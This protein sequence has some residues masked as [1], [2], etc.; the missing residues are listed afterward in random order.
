M[1][2]V[3]LSSMTSGR[4]AVLA[5][6]VRRDAAPMDFSR[7]FPAPSPPPVSQPASRPASPAGS[8]VATRRERS[9]TTWDRLRD[10]VTLSSIADSLADAALSLPLD[11]DSLS[12]AAGS[13]A[14]GAACVAMPGHLGL[15]AAQAL[16]QSPLYG[17]GLTVAALGT[18]CL[19]GTGLMMGAAMSTD[20]G[21]LAGVWG[22]LTGAVAA[23][24]WVA[25]RFA[26]T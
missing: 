8:T 11:L 6:A 26:S 21:S 9:E 14:I 16:P 15:L 19:T 24:L 10:T 2:N 22:S 23:G 20:N 1:A 3:T 4:S 18:G 17:A 25:L 5:C 7:L 13:A 12:M